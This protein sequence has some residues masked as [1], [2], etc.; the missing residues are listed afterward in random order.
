MKRL[1][2]ASDDLTEL[3]IYMRND[4]AFPRS[5]AVRC[6]VGGSIESKWFSGT[7]QNK[8]I[9]LEFYWISKQIIHW[10]FHG[11]KALDTIIGSVSVGAQRLKTRND[12][13]NKWERALATQFPRSQD[14]IAAAYRNSEEI[15]RQ[16]NERKKCMFARCSAMQYVEMKWQFLLLL[17]NV[18]QQHLSQSFRRRRVINE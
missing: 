4:H 7:T 8:R 10:A 13:E 11:A 6:I 18:L 3:F 5:P 14:R 1:S 16:S 17:L 2:N 12:N 9:Y 15:I